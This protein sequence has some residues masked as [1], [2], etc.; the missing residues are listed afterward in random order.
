MDDNKTQGGGAK[1]RPLASCRRPFVK[2]FLRNIRTERL[3]NKFPH[4]K[5]PEGSS[6]PTRVATHP[7]L[8]QYYPIALR[9]CPRHRALTVVVNSGQC[10]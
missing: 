2:D 7:R 1:R 10:Q 3:K 8:R 5:R 6:K 4:N 9:A